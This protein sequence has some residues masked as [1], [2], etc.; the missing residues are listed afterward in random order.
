MSGTPASN[1]RR[2]LVGLRGWRP[3]RSSASNEL[4]AQALL[5]R[6]PSAQRLEL[7]HNV[8]VTA[9]RQIGV[10]A[11]RA[12]RGAPL[13]QPSDL[14]LREGFEDRVGQGRATPQ[15]QRLAQ[16][17]GRLGR[18]LL[19]RRLAALAHKWLETGR[20][21]ARRLRPARI[22]LP[23]PGAARP[24]GVKRATE[25]TDMI[26]KRLGGRR[27][28]RIAHTASMSRSLAVGSLRCRGG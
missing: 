11:Q 5:P 12:R 8:R 7:A 15:R 20:G 1:T 23:A 25:L 13:L 26:L 17:S 27:R 6:T 3:Q 16:A 19:R 22:G 14:A 21:R 24:R 9:K 2:A 28:Q 4:G 10:N 18:S